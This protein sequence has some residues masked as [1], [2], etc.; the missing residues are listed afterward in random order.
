[1]KKLQNCRKCGKCEEAC[2]QNIKIRNMLE[3]V[4]KTF[5]P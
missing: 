1:M 4:V 5:E 2:P 3:E